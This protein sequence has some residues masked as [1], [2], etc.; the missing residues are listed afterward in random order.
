VLLSTKQIRAG[1]TPGGAELR[2][3]L[4]EHGSLAFVSEG[5]SY[6]RMELYRVGGGTP[7]MPDTPPRSA[8]PGGDLPWVLVPVAVVAG[9]AAARLRRL[10]GSERVSGVGRPTARRTAGIVAATACIGALTLVLV[11]S[12]LPG[13]AP[14][15]VGSPI[16]E[17]RMT[18]PAGSPQPTPRPSP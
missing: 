14:G 3:W 5:P 17:P 7:A 1:Y 12:M 15:T 13:P 4:E 2:S 16:D 11:T 8:L 18:I 6:E 9:L 10:R